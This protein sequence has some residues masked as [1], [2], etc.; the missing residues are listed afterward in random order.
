MITKATES[1]SKSRR[2]MMGDEQH[3]TQSLARL[4]K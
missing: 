2:A 4:K 3:N 1:A